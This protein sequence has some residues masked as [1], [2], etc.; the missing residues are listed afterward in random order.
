MA[1]EKGQ[2]AMQGAQIAPAACMLP[3]AHQGLSCKHDHDVFVACKGKDAPLWWAC[4]T[5]V[6]K[7]AGIVKGA[8]Y[9]A[10]TCA[11]CEWP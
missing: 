8:M 11:D 5:I 9:S 4:G 2:K 10:D 6:P 1:L 7:H 3:T